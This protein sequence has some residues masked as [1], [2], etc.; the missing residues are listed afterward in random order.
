MSQHLNVT[1]LGFYLN[2]F[3]SSAQLF[4]FPLLALS[5]WMIKLRAHWHHSTHA[6]RLSSLAWVQMDEMGTVSI[7]WSDICWLATF[8]RHISTFS[9]GICCVNMPINLGTIHKGHVHSWGGRVGQ[10]ADVLREV[11]LILFCRLAQVQT[12][13]GR[14]SKIQTILRMFFTNGSQHDP[15]LTFVTLTNSHCTSPRQLCH[16]TQYPL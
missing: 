2:V 5:T 16:F 10:K 14:G 4:S 11:E 9:S 7:S 1:A 13:G 6:H 8:L 12:R 3:G 15:Y